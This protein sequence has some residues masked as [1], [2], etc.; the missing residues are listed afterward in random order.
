MTLATVLSRAKIGIDA[1][2]IQV[3][4]HLS[5]GLPALNIVGMPEAAVKESKDRV[6]SAIINSGFEF[7]QRR[8]TINLAPA[9]LPKE[10]ARFDLPIALGILAASQQIPLELVGHHCFVGELA[11]SGHLREIQG[12]LPVAIQCL[13]ASQKVF[14]PADNLREASL[15]Q[16]GE[17]LGAFHLNDLIAAMLGQRPF[18]E[19]Q[20]NQIQD[21][22]NLNT[23][24]MLDLRDIKGQ[25]HGKRAL[26]V[27][28]A[29]KHN[30]LMMG[31]PGTGK[32]ML[33]ERLPSLLPPL[34]E[35]ERLEVAAIQSL[36]RSKQNAAHVNP[37]NYNYVRPLRSPHHTCS[38]VALVG[39]GTYPKPGEI[40][41]AHNGVLFL[42]ELPEFS[43]KV[44]DVL[45]EPMESGE[46][47]ISRANQQV[48]YPSR[49]QLIAAMNPCKCGYI[50]QP[51]RRCG[52]CTLGAAKK[53]QGAI[54]GP[55]LDRIDIQIEIPPLPSGLI[56]SDTPQASSEDYK[57]AIK[58]AHTI[59]MDRNQGH[60][61]AH[62]SPEQVKAYCKLQ[63]CDGEFLE[64]AINKLGLSAR[65]YGRI[66]KVARTIADLE[67]SQDIQRTHINEALGYRTLERLI[68]MGN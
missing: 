43:R 6:R 66:I 15:V 4:V 54:S 36:I 31:P 55:L 3:E 39:G 34:T 16:D 23:I 53:Y 29:G 2:V 63:K 67:Q 46:I 11:L 25:N 21:E 10:G 42:D 65:A 56:S 40:S 24:G 13:K 9:E 64:K 50:N 32:T 18:A 68:R 27:A 20:Y 37:T 61:N 7:P 62:L 22:D 47:S 19:M 28:A 5:A 59:Q 26:Q 51:D 60:A 33:A 14:M 52:D 38:G 30:L 58:L 17:Q 41:L 8:I 57:P 45:R 49:F 48:T 1:P 12:V 44:L 35:S